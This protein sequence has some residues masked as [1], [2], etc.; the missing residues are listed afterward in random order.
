MHP[1]WADAP[2]NPI[3]YAAK[4]STKQTWW[5]METLYNKV[6]DGHI[7][8]IGHWGQHIALRDDKKEKQLS[9]APYIQGGILTEYKVHQ[10]P[11]G[12]NGR[13]TEINEGQVEEEI[14]HG[15]VEVR[16]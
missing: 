13:V 2:A 5:D 10:H 9:H 7:V 6:T 16:I 15:G 12:E 8:I 14:V 11:G 1:V 4:E 3:T